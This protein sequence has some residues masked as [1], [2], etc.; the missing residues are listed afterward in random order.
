V[1]V[2]WKEKKHVYFDTTTDIL[3]VT[4]KCYHRSPCNYDPVCKWLAADLHY[5]LWFLTSLIKCHTKLLK[6]KD[7]ERWCKKIQA[8]QQPN[9]SGINSR[10]TLTFRVSKT[11][12]SFRIAMTIHSCTK[13]CSWTIA[14]LGYSEWESTKANI[15]IDILW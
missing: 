9:K 14:L 3:Q 13:I 1:V 11:N 4:D 8:N 7:F 5:V 12:C 6:L 10:I 15:V 2:S